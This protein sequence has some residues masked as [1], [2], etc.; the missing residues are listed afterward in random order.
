MDKKMKE[1]L[2]VASLLLIITIMSVTS[3][4]NINSFQKNL[5]ESEVASVVVKGNEFISKL[6]YAL[7]Y[8]KEINNFYGMNSLIKDWKDHYEE[9]DNASI[10]LMDG[11]I[12]YAYNK[13]DNYDS[14]NIISSIPF[15]E[16]EKYKI[17]N[18]SGKIEILLP[19]YDSTNTQIAAYKIALNNKIINS[20]LSYYTNKLIKI[21]IILIIFA[22]IILGIF[23]IKGSYVKN[24]Q[25]SKNRILIIILSVVGLI[26]ILYSVYSYNMFS[27][28]YVDLSKNIGIS[29]INSIDRDITKIINNGVTYSQIGEYEDYL[30]NIAELIPQIESINL[31]QLTA[32]EDDFKYRFNEK[33]LKVEKFTIV[34]SENKCALI[35]IK[36][37]K[38]YI[39]SALRIILLDSIT[40]FATSF[41]FMVEIVLFLILYI[42]NAN[43]KYMRNHEKSSSFATTSYTGGN[44]RILSYIVYT[45][46]YMPVSFVPLV[47]KELY[48]SMSGGGTSDFLMGL[49]IS[50][51][52]FT[53]ALF[54]VVGGKLIDNIGW[55]K[56]MYIGTGILIV[57]TIAS[58]ISNNV[59]LFILSRGFYGVGYALIYI[60]MRSFSASF[61]DET[62]KKNGFASITAGVYAG[63]NTGAVFGAILMEKIGYRSVFLISSVIMGI[64][65]LIIRFYFWESAEDK[66]SHKHINRGKSINTSEKEKLGILK[67][68]SNPSIIGF[69]LL[70]TVPMAMTVI[71]LDYFYPV[72]ASE[73]KIGTGTIGRAYLINGIFV[74][75]IS[76]ILLK[77]MGNKLSKLKSV[78]FSMLLVSASFIVFAMLN[79]PLGMLLASAILGLGEG[80]GLAS[81]TEYYLNL[82]AT[83]YIGKG[84]ALGY[85]SNIRKISQTFGPQIFAIL[86]IFG[87]NV[88]IGILGI[89]TLV[90]VTLF[91]IQTFYNKRK[92]LV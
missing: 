29:T 69:F 87:Y 73:F 51:V 77:Y 46:C 63:V 53:G 34:D 18:E 14:K 76:P 12:K 88:G 23:S 39:K 61:K 56:V 66:E 50:I 32:E 82:K 52:F 62:S 21:A 25:I 15:N 74:A 65:V 48:T 67:F 13:I 38:A 86:L 75:Y 85:Y 68:L 8:G 78:V 79:S 16:G 36:I 70:I 44:L 9:V 17:I 24:G 6:Q 58:G 35:N 27:S 71:F 89:I 2:L 81:Q 41:F 72:Y 59:F 28:A 42:M 22:F 43:K 49:P 31:T 7:K 54:T 90:F 55:K 26:Q 37:D 11:E 3:F 30:N 19:I 5:I 40:I 60:S 83:T 91:V 33:D 20:K 45:A 1:K 64:A 10:L 92:E 84:E 4:I 80:V 57:S 47:M